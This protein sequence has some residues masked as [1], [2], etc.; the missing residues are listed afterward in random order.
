MGQENVTYFVAFVAGLLTFLSPC[1]LPLIPSFIAYIT[2]VAFND[3]K[4][5]D[6]KGEVRFKT[7]SHTLLFIAGFSIV[8][9]ILGLTATAIGRALFNYQ[10]A[11]RIGGGILVII[12]GFYLTGLLKLDFLMKERQIHAKPGG[13]TYVGSFLVGVTFAAAWTPCAGPILGSILVLAGTESSVSRGAMLLVL[14][15]AGLAVPF[16]ITAI[17]INHFLAALNRFTRIFRYI[18]IVGGS[19]LIIVGILMVTNSM[20]SISEK[21]LT[22]FQ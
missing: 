3:L 17:A 19:F 9:I 22:L 15:S 10:S 20:Q 1:I 18:N 16:I 12:F 11:I 14:Y 4:S 13:A 21:L 6:L 8:F 7:I 2:G 5:K